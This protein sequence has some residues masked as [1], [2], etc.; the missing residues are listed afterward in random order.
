VAESEDLYEVLQVHPGAHPEVVQAAYLRLA[1][2]Y[3]PDKNPSPEASRSAMARI[4]RAFEIL[5]DPEKRAT[6]DQTRQGQANPPAARPLDQAAETDEPQ[7]SPRRR[8]RQPAL[9]YFTLGSRKADVTRIQGPPAHTS[10]NEDRGEEC[11][12]YNNVGVVFFDK[13]GRTTGWSNFGGG[14]KI[15]LV[16]GPNVTTADFFSIDSHKD[17]VARLQGTPS[18][19]DTEWGT[20]FRNENDLVGRDAKV[21]ETWNFSSGIVEFSID[22]GRV[23]G[24]EKTNDS[25]KARSRTFGRPPERALPPDAKAGIDFFTWGP[26]SWMSKEF[27]GNQLILGSRSTIRKNGVTGALTRLL[28]FTAKFERG[29]TVLGTI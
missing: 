7:A 12:T 6:Y 18:W 8:T 15:K 11:W 5:G 22:T 14:L 19:I 16:P 25:M 29:L 17:D 9:D 3:D 27:K 10:L 28:S 1:L 2:L 23:T 20:K 24:W 21:R 13:A 4:N 26:A